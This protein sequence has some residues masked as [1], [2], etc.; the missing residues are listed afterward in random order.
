MS[1]SAAKSESA[2]IEIRTTSDK[3]ELL[4]EAASISGM[5]LTD[6]IMSNAIEKASQ[7]IQEVTSM[8][9]ALSDFNKMMDAL[10][11]PPEPAD[12][13]KQSVR[14]LQQRGKSFELHHRA[15]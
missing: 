6:F 12:H 13:L 11:N 14:K 5:N 15:V 10:D 9:V 1:V 4:K 7:R 8:N 2:R 3:K